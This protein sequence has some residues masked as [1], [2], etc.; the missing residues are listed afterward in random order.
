M[1]R[2]PELDDLRAKMDEAISGMATK[3]ILV[4]PETIKD[5]CDIVL[6]TN[7]V[8]FDLQEARKAGHEKI[9]IPESYL[10]TLITP[11][12]H[13]FF[14]TGIGPLLG[15]VIQGI[16]HTSSVIEFLAPLYCDTPYRIELEFAG[17]VR[18]RGKMG[19]Y[20]V[21]TYPHKVLDTRDELMAVDRHI[22]FLRAA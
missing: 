2:D 4:P 12:S 15:P 17:L 3:E 1:A 14:T 16:I 21:G 13:E 8:Y 5:F 22:F 20:F 18:K 7:P 9:P 19:E 10:L 11:L 6:E